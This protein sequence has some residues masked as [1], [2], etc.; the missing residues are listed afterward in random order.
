MTISF[1]L[2]LFY[3]KFHVPEV[4]KLSEDGACAL[5]YSGS[6][7]WRVLSAALTSFNTPED[8]HTI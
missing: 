5:L 7:S 6:E 2:L 8:F 4:N 1:V 3:A